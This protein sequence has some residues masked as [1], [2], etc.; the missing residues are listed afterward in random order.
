MHCAFPAFLNGIHRIPNSTFGAPL[1]NFRDSAMGSL[2]DYALGPELSPQSSYG[3]QW[4]LSFALLQPGLAGGK[5]IRGWGTRW[6]QQ[7]EVGKNLAVREKG[8]GRRP[9]PLK[10]SLGIHHSSSARFLS[11]LWFVTMFSLLTSDN[12]WILD[13]DTLSSFILYLLSLFSL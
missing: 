3:C 7:L 5:S 12:I 6:P 13:K 10:A 4:S 8:S 9:C 2:A 1:P 11:T